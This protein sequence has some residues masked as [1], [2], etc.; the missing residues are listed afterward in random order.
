MSP[1]FV[2]DTVMLVVMP[3][4]LVVMARLALKVPRRR[5]LDDL[6]D[7][8]GL[9]RYKKALIG[10][11]A[12]FGTAAGIAGALGGAEV[13]EWLKDNPAV[14][15][16][17]FAGMWAAM[18]L[19]LSY[20]IATWESRLVVG[21]VLMV[22][23]ALWLL[24]PHWLTAGVL[25]IA[26]CTALVGVWKPRL[27]FVWLFLVVLAVAGAYD[28]VQVFVTGDMVA[29][30]LSALDAVLPLMVVVPGEPNLFAKPESG[31]GLGDI[32]TSAILL[33][34]AAR[35]AQRTKTPW[36]LYGGIVGYVVADLAVIAVGKITQHFQPATIYFVPGIAAGIMLAA[37]LTG[38]GAELRRKQEDLPARG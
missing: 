14:L 28:A 27:P 32:V 29:A 11:S 1:K 7:E 5:P 17:A 18:T 34:A 25:G 19:A 38:H 35:I 15:R 9:L 4:V 30:L 20:F 16:Y 31:L 36:I 8:L 21:S 37:V 22:L 13:I 6:I 33:V 10:G 23:V 12:L 26:L 2:A 24:W 3:V